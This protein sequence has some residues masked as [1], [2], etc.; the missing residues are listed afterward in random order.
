MDTMNSATPVVPVL[1][2]GGTERV[3]RV[4]RY[5][6]RHGLYVNCILTPVVPKTAERLRCIVTADH[7]REDLDT[8]VGIIAEA[9]AAIP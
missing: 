6:Q 1:V 2:P 4:G 7:T 9:C 3:L 8:A 5:C